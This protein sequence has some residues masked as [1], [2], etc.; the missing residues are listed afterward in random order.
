MEPHYLY[1]FLISLLR[2]LSRKKL[3]TITVF[4]VITISTLCLGIIWP[5]KYETTATLYVDQ[6]NIIEPLLRGQA[7]VQNINQVQEA[8]EKIYTREILEKVARDAHLLT[9]DSSSKE[10]A[11]IITLLGD[12][13]AGIRIDNNGKNYLRLSYKN[14]D[15]EK[16]FN[17][18]TALINAFIR[19]IAESKR[20]ESKEAYDFIENQVQLYRAQLV[21]AEN[22]LENFNTQ[23][24]DG[25]EASV[26]ERITSLQ[27]E[28]EELD[29]SINEIQSKK[30]SIKQQ[31][32]VEQE[33]LN[34]RSQTDVY[35]Q[36]IQE[37]QARID[38]L[39]ISLTE[40][41]PDVVSLKLQIQDYKQ[42]I[43]DIENSNRNDLQNQNNSQLSINPLFEEL[44]SNLSETEIDLNT[45]IDRKNALEKL[46]EENYA[47][48]KRL[49]M[50]SAKLSELTRGYN[51]TKK[52]YEDMLNS[53]EKARLSMTLDIEGQGTS[54]KVHEP[55]TFPL[56]PSGLAMWHFLLLAPLAGLMTPIGF[57][58][59]YIFLDPRI[60]LPSDL[61]HIPNCEILAIFPP[62]KNALFERLAQKNNLISG[63]ILLITISAYAFICFS[64]YVGAF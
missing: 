54:Y 35:R 37:T 25:T 23:N 41:H 60:R 58:A 10:I 44:R 13:R 28:I 24:Y 12:Q 32:K 42:V 57:I 36:R 40:T 26:N 29:L 34:L 63:L 14:T 22:N 59:T 61:N 11:T 7:E 4:G 6:R 39:L 5:L 47:R 33:Y 53:K 1:E 64:Y 20:Q 52:L 46:L 56:E 51:V 43:K 9:K 3:L 45:S 16:S 48:S 62:V 49:S 8:S 27:R 50:R 31:L 17:V 55:P 19:N 38:N 2:E 18:I 21:E 30:H 15:A